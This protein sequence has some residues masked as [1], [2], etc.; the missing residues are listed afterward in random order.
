MF[1]DLAGNTL[2][3]AQHNAFACGFLG[4]ESFGWSTLVAVEPASL[5]DVEAATSGARPHS[6]CAELGAPSPAEARAAAEAEVA[7][8]AGL[9]DHPPGTL[10]TVTR[11]FE[12]DGIAERYATITPQDRMA[13]VHAAP[14]DLRAPRRRRADRPARPRRRRADRTCAPSPQTGRQTCAPSSQTGCH[15]DRAGRDAGRRSDRRVAGGR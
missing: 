11:R 9:C 5:A 10:L 13:A 3:Q 1:V 4:V 8:A 14:I 2:S 7:F 12:G 6:S 15:H